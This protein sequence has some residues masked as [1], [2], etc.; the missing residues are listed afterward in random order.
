MTKPE[1]PTG[2]IDAFFAAD[3]AAFALARCDSAILRA[4]PSTA[5]TGTG[6]YGPAPVEP[7]SIALTKGSADVTLKPGVDAAR[8]AEHRATVTAIEVR[9]RTLPWGFARAAATLVVR[10]QP[11]PEGVAGGEVVVAESLAASEEEAQ[12]ELAPMRA[13]LSALT[14]I[15]EDAPA[16]RPPEDAAAP[17]SASTRYSMHL[18]GDRI[19]LR[20]HDSSG[21]RERVGR[22]RMLAL[23]LVVLGIVGVAVFAERL[24]AGAPVA[25]LIGVGVVPLVVFIGAFA[26]NEIARYAARYAGKSAPLAWFADD[27]IV[28]APWVSREGAVDT[29]PEGRLGAAVACGEVHGVEVRSR[30]GA[31]AVTIDGLHGPI[32]VAVTNDQSIAELL[33]VTVET[34]IA[35]VSSPKKRV[36]ALMR[37]AT[38]R[39]QAARS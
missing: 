31:L 25:A 37:A 23:I 2:L 26:M 8:K 4:F 15:G 5:A 3:A 13:A 24:N 35:K 38:A 7:V 14:G 22:Y 32:E 30:E 20:D 12:A 18:E 27:G 9:T 29:K 19:V 28:V 33:R 36:T 16:S 11:A 10:L 6:D 1:D 21:P 17:R 39:E 34:A